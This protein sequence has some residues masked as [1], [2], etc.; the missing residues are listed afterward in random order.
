M[1][2]LTDEKTQDQSSHRSKDP[3]LQVGI[4]MPTL[5]CL[6]FSLFFHPHRSLLTHYKELMSSHYLNVSKASI[7]EPEKGKYLS[8]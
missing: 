2:Q 3:P 4:Q 7:C 8:T 6:S 5:E 1:Q